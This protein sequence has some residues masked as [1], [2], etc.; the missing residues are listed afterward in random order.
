VLA[1][2]ATQPVVP[3]PT[4][5]GTLLS[6]ICSW[7]VIVALV[8]FH[9]VVS[10]IGVPSE[11][12]EASRVDL[13]HVNLLARVSV[14]AQAMTES[15]RLPVQPPP[16]RPDD[17]PETHWGHAIILNEVQGPNKALQH[18]DETDRS[19][20]RFN[21]ELTPDQQRLR[22]ILRRMIAEQERGDLDASSVS[23]ADREFLRQRMGFLGYLTEHP[24]QSSDEA[25]RREL[26]QGAIRFL[27]ITS[28]IGLV[29]AAGLLAGVAALILAGVALVAGKFRSRYVAGPLGHAHIYGE[30]FAVWFLLF[31][32][33]QVLV[34]GLV[35][36]QWRLFGAGA[37][38]FISLVSLGWPRW[39][40]ISWSDIRTDIGLRSGAHPL[41]EAGWGLV[42][43]I[44]MTPVIVVAVLILV[45]ISELAMGFDLAIAQFNGK[46]A[47]THPIVFELEQGNTWAIIT[48]MVLA[49]LAAPVVEETMFRG[50]LYRH[51][52]ESSRWAGHWLSVLFSAAWN[53][54]IFAAIHPQGLLAIPILG[55]LAFGFS[56]VR[57][58]RG[59]L[60]APMMMHAVNNGIMV[61]LLVLLFG[62]L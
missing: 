6:Y 13:M 37:A 30:T 12:T 49:C 4:T 35:P 45:T 16:F 47:P 7:T 24:R 23:I 20:D 17:Y 38:F 11:R 18:L 8:L 14:G 15:S 53:A 58:W 33:L 55:T 50:V 57:E 3:M 29:A 26:E 2:E 43:Y 60:I 51:L 52:R 48:V 32:S 36:G 31:T 41:V 40:G 19:L 44:A 42:A 46:N 1:E 62:N 54:L 59:S 27:L 56:L 39:R 9:A 22:D 34:G 28:G 10:L 25:A 21:I 61:T 5:A